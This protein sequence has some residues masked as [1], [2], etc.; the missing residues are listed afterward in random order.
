MK[1]LLIGAGTW[2][3]NHLRVLSELGQ[4]I[5][6]ADT[7]EEK[8]KL[9]KT[10]NINAAHFTTDYH[11]FLQKV[12]AVDIASPTSTHFKIAVECLHAKRHVL[13]EKP[14]SENVREANE[15]VKLAEEKALVLM[16][17]HVFIYNPVTDYLNNL[18]HSGILGKMY[19]VYGSFS[20][21][22]D[23]RIDS[24]TTLTYA[25]HYI[26]VLNHL[27]GQPTRVRGITKKILQR[28][29]EDVTLAIVEY[30]DLFAYFDCSWLNPGK[31]R[32]LVMVGS[33]GSLIADFLNQKIW[34]DHGR[35]E[36][37]KAIPG[38]VEPI[39][40]E[41]LKWREPLKLEL[42]N[43]IDCIVTHKQPISNGKNALEVMKAIQHI[44]TSN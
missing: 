17:G 6:L 25:T 15:L 19:Y 5:Y 3:K 24:G 27:F 37:D 38:P 20:G 14:I 29:F 35:H 18:I 34:I 26:S 4:D 40:D 10:N 42:Q 23:L 7:D 13:V 16:V 12:D 41:A 32:H 33:K 36:G 22:K 8:I 44:L 9:C 2:G 1:I 30:G 11:D 21:L 28:K 39:I 43:F 31:N